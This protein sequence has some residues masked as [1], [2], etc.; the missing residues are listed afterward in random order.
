MAASLGHRLVTVACALLRASLG[1]Y[2]GA[3]RPPM[4]LPIRLSSRLL[5]LGIALLCLAPGAAR[6]QTGGQAEPEQA[7][8]GSAQTPTQ[9]ELPVERPVEPAPTFGEVG[10]LDRLERV[11]LGL[12]P[13]PGEVQLSGI[14]R[15][16]DQPTAPPPPNPVRRALDTDAGYWRL[17]LGLQQL[18]RSGLSGSPGTVD[19]RRVQLGLSWFGSGATTAG[20]WDQSG[21]D[22]WRGFQRGWSAGWSYEANQYRFLNASGI[23]FNSLEPIEDQYQ[24]TL[25][26]RNAGDP[27]ATWALKWTLSASV[28]LE[29]EA[30]ISESLTY[31]GNLAIRWRRSDDFAWVIG[32]AAT[33]Q[34][35]EDVEILPFVGV[36]WRINDRTTLETLG[37]AWE[38]RYAQS[39]NLNIFGRAEYRNRQYRL[40]EL[41][42]LPAGAFH[43]R[44]LLIT[45]GVEWDPGFGDDWFRA[46][47]V[48]LYGGLAPWHEID[49]RANDA[50][51]GDTSVDPG[52]VLGISAWFAF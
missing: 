45:G 32:A 37:P 38:L 12:E 43:D 9:D 6:A 27:D 11:L 31:G 22:P 52:L 1:G 50:F 15:N 3:P 35:E 39:E 48:R 41:G 28:G 23:L 18:S 46:G 10:T 5:P 29:K 13:T 51:A 2:P 25:W 24:H 7:D 40:D 42:P 33:S 16:F 21:D 34:L 17:D 4:R 20:P 19:T 30:E 26:L 36:D 8:G 14:D 44:E 49:F 47:R